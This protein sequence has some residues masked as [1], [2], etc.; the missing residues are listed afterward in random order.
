M[1][2]HHRI[3]IGFYIVSGDVCAR[4]AELFLYLDSA[5]QAAGNFSRAESA[6][7]YVVYHL[8][9]DGS[10]AS[11]IHIAS[12]FHCHLEVDGVGVVG[13]GIYGGTRLVVD[14]AVEKLERRH[15][16][17][18]CCKLVKVKVVGADAYIC[19]VGYT[20]HGDFCP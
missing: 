9:G 10:V 12:I 7:G 6:L 18:S 2:K 19:A 15:V 16:G 3:G 4:D 1:G 11:E 5:R 17:G 14:L 8:H 13:I 20:G